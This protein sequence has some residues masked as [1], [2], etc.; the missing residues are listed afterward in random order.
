MEVIARWLK[1][2]G[3]IDS[4]RLERIARTGKTTKF[5]SSARP[6][7]TEVLITDVGVGVSQ[8]FQSS[9]SA[10]TRPRARLSSSSSPR[11]IFTRASK[12]TSPTS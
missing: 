11:S 3:V 5:A 4:F 12:P 1:Q 7:P 9:F 8:V 2:L 10:F 6:S